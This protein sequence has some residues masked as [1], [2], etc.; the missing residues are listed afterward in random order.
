LE[1]VYESLDCGSPKETS[2]MLAG[3]LSPFLELPHRL[4]RDNILSNPCLDI[5][6][7][8]AELSEV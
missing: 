1:E 2:V 3:Y 5:P 8:T 6:K 7:S 4:A